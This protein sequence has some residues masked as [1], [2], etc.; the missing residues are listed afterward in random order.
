MWSARQRFLQVLHSSSRV[1]ET[2]DVTGRLPHAWVH[3][4]TGV[5][6]LDVVACVHHCRPPGVRHVLP[7]FDAQ[8]A[9]VPDRSGSSVDLG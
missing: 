8:R 3:E 5:E 7:Q 6:P 1:G 4:D 2:G 9:V